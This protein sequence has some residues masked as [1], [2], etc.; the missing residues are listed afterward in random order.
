[1]D[2]EIHQKLSPGEVTGILVSEG[3]KVR[4][5]TL[6]GG[7]VVDT[8][9]FGAPDFEEY[10]SMAHTRT[11]LYST[12]FQKGD[13]L[14]SNY[15]SPLLVFSEDTTDGYHDSL[16]AACSAASYTFFGDTERYPNCEDNLQQTLR[17]YGIPYRVTPPPWNLFEK[18][19][20]SE[21][22]L[23]R[24]EPTSA[25]EGDYVELLA[26]QDLLL[27]FSACRS[28]IGNIQNGKPSG[29]EISVLGK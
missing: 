29:V 4:V 24:D 19:F 9:A 8:W 12:R 23:I 13:A 26:S 11:A 17:E 16:H 27:V 2:A 15:F 14:V 21:D 22:G 28:T 18:S 10:L 25:K 6:S 7:Q 20:V 1:M 5:A 3:Q